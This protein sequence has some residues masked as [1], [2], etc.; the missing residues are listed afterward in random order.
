MAS[1]ITSRAVHV[2]GLVAGYA[3]TPA[4]HGIDLS[5]EEGQITVLLGANGAGKT[6]TLLAIAGGIP[7]MGGTVEVL[8]DTRKRRLDHR[9]RHGLGFLTEGR[10]VFSD[11]TGAENL[12]LG[13][14]EATKA[15][16]F[17]PELEPHLGKRAGLMSGGQQ[18]M[19]AL[20]RILAGEP[21][22][23][24]ADE[25]SLGLAPLVVQRL[26][27]A[28]R[29]AADRGVAVILVEQHIR[30]ALRI[31]DRGCVLRRGRIVLDGTGTE[32]RAAQDE[33]AGHYLDERH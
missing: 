9:A 10:C 6:T 3:G 1:T 7:L 23:L 19:L 12:S 28:L 24:L 30:Q 26:L 15:L 5:V 22:V 31:A 29:D 20:G 25:L 4:V 32:L 27:T 17:F 16:E 14:G 21:R 11:L 2:Q 13:R 18:Q 8:G 33:I